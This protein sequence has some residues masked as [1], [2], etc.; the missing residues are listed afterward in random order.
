MS[1]MGCTP[2]TIFTACPVYC[3]PG[4]EHAL[5]LAMTQIVA[6][7]LSAEACTVTFLALDQL[8]ITC[9]FVPFVPEQFKPCKGQS[10]SS[11]SNFQQDRS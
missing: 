5:L 8:L 11:C 6:T 9:I 1:V 7:A 10:H 3:M 4:I 2:G